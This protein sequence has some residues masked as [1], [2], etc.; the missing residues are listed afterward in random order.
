MVMLLLFCRGRDLSL[1]WGFTGR[2]AINKRRACRGGIYAAR[3]FPANDRLPYTRGPHI[4]GPYIS[5]MF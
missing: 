2:H 3:N 5:T 1:P 4:C